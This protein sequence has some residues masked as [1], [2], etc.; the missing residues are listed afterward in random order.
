MTSSGATTTAAC[1]ATSTALDDGLFV[2]LEIVEQGYAQP[3]T[4]A[5]NTTFATAFVAAAG[6]G[7]ASRPSACGPPAPEPADS[8][9]SV[10]SELTLAERLGY[11]RRRP[12]RHP[13]VRRPRLVPRRQ[14]RR[15]PGAPRRC[16]HLRLADGAGAVGVPRRQQAHSPTT[17]SAST[18]R[19]TASTT[20][21]LGA[22]HP[23]AVAAVRR[24]RVPPHPRR[25]VGARRPRRGAPRA[26]GPDRTGAR[27]GHR[28]HPPRPAPLGDHAAAR[29]LR[30]LPRTR[31]RVRAADPPAV[32]HHA[33]SRPDS[34]SA[35]W[36]PRKASSSPTTSTTTGGPAAPTACTRR[37]TTC[38]RA[39][40]RSTCSRR[41]TR[42]RCAPSSDA[43]DG[44]ID[45]LAL[46]T[47]DDLR[48]AARR[49]RRDHASATA[50]CATRCAPRSPTRD[51]ACG[52]PRT[53]LRHGAGQAARGRRWPWRPRRTSARRAP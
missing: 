2:N 39:S 19:S 13:L 21:P 1:S 25:P 51:R 26:A 40:P 23:R 15:V 50:T 45:D 18:S 7:R 9:A 12:A 31:R 3:L 34:R 11:R 33:P 41:S 32:D 20:L 49:Q 38:S 35:S 5:P 8:V 22:D 52:E 48:D 36:R 43:A 29:V 14:R 16:R 24:G 30:R 42:P 17:T 53:R 10:A 37:S 4:I 27:V 46:V 6:D 44:W 28:R 47:S